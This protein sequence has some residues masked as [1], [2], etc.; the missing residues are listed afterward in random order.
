[1]SPTGQA[2]MSGPAVKKESVETPGSQLSHGP[3][4]RHGSAGLYGGQ[5][6]KT[7]TLANTQIIHACRLE[8]WNEIFLLDF[9]QATKKGFAL[10]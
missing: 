6:S 7:D 8:P 4:G 10:T 1:M 5:N 9:K 2:K 3:E